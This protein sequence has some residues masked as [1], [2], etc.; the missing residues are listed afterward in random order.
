MHA[1]TF[2]VFVSE[3]EG[4]HKPQCFINRSSYR[5]VI[6]GDLA[7]IAFVINNEKS[8]VKKKGYILIKLHDTS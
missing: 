6:H 4:L 8:S 7:E 3:L 5:E 1:L 2:S